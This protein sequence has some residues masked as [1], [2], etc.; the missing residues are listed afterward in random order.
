MEIKKSVISILASN[1]PDVLARIA[2]TFSGRGFNIDSITANVTGNP[3]ITRIIITTQGNQ[4]TIIKIEKELNRLVDVHQVT[5]LTSLDLPLREMI[6][7][8]MPMTG[9]N[10]EKIMEIVDRYHGEVIET[11][12]GYGILELTGK[13]EDMDNA[14]SSLE[15]LGIDDFVRTGSVTL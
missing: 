12:S 10:H 1:K 5:D 6:L 15:L 4:D 3:R 7:I 14:L 11:G 13:K 8:R 2:G 9:E